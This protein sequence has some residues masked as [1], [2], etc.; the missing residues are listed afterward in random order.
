M[1]ESLNIPTPLHRTLCLYHI[2][3]S[4]N[5]SFRAATPLTHQA[6]LPHQHSSLS[7][8]CHHWI[9]SDDENSSLNSNQL[10]DRMELSLPVEQ[11]MCHC[12]TDNSFQDVTSEEEEEEEEEELFPTAPLDDK[13]WMEET[14]PDRHLCI[15]EQSKP[16]DLCPL[17]LPIQLVSAT[18]TP[19][20][21]SA[22]WHM[23]LRNLFDFP[24]VMTT[25]SDEDI[26]SLEDF[27]GL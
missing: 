11:P 6:H 24:D 19:E 8:V 7:S 14:V 13:I 23:D 26:L 12:L 17:P 15:H 4:E 21:A 18:P 5:L 27:F 10:H 2:S 9:F 16:H 22:P 20:Y 3:T 1:S 25:T